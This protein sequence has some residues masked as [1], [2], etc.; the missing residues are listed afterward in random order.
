VRTRNEDAV[1]VDDPHSLWAVAD[2][3]GGH[4][5]GHEASTGLLTA[6]AHCLDARPSAAR[7]STLVH[8]IE[9]ATERVHHRLR[10]AALRDREDTIAT[11]LAAV[12][13]TGPLA[14][15]LWAGDSRVYH[16]RG[17]R[18]T[19]LTH[20]H[21]A[22]S[23]ALTRAV[24]AGPQ[25]VLETTLASLSPRDRLLLCTDGLTKAIPD[26]ELTR[27][28]NAEPRRRRCVDRLLS[29]ALERGGRDNISLVLVEA[30]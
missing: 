5:R 24:G 26:P 29:T 12:V 23:G 2:G 25:C 20:D 14:L 9:D 13:M 18:C 6:L 3:L 11:T 7:P 19:C 1:L 17:D 4:A 30:L 28:L 27:L 16:Q 21:V 10:A 15:V 22:D 8:A